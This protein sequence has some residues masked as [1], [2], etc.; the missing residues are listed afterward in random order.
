MGTTGAAMLLIRLLL[1]TNSQ[2]KYTAH[3]VLFFIAMVANCGGI[4]TPL[5]DPP[6]FLLFQK[7]TP[8][9]WFMG[10]APEWLVTGM[11]M[12]LVYYVMD[13]IYYKRESMERIQADIEATEKITVTGLINLVW[14]AAVILSTM[15]INSTY[16]PAMGEYDAP[17]YLKLLREWAFILIIILI[18]C[19]L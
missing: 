7:G 13:T 6:L 19:L 16:F 11:L 14:L 12:L 5:G 15:F 1:Q 8:F 9:G 4:L 2:R 18:L 10:L 3:T 17:F